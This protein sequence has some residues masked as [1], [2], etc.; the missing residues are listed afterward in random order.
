MEIHIYHHFDT[1]NHKLDQILL[2]IKKLGEQMS[3][4]TQALLKAIDDATNAI[5]ARIQRLID[6]SNDPA[7]NAALQAEVDKLVALGKDPEVKTT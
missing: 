5:A 1:D 7:L 3:T 4:E 6:A 2:G